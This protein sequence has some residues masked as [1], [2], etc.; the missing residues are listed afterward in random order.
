MDQGSLTTY[1]LFAVHFSQFLNHSFPYAFAKN[2][3]GVAVIDGHMAD[4][5]GLMLALLE[6]LIEI[7]AIIIE[8]FQYRCLIHVLQ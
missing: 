6:Q 2:I 1:A 8:C 4:C 7:S 3:H 5:L